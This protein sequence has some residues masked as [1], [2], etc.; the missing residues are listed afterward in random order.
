MSIK[1][2]PNCIQ[3][4]E[5][6]QEA[7]A[8]AFEDGFVG[9]DHAKVGLMFWYIKKDGLYNIDRR[10]ATSRDNDILR[11]VKNA[12]NQPEFVGWPDSLRESIK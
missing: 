4:G 9:T 6:S 2:K 10:A 5:F 7:I 3:A 1:T 8:K 12:E 11:G